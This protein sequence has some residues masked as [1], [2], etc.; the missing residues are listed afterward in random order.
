MMKRIA[1]MLV[2]VGF[3]AGCVTPSQRWSS[4]TSAL[5]TAREVTMTL[6]KGG[7]IDDGAL[8]TAHDLD[9]TVRGALDVAE[10]QLPDGGDTFEQFMAVAEG[11]LKGL[12]AT[13]SKPKEIH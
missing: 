7:A 10:T 5:Q 12:A 6:H 11:G 9:M 4:A 3:L 13:Y 8:K 1:G 2:I